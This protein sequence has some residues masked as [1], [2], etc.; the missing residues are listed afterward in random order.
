M[1]AE[2]EK[3]VTAKCDVLLPNALDAIPDDGTIPRP[4]A[5]VKAV[6]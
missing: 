5:R 3:I 2:P 1:A 4:C 6:V